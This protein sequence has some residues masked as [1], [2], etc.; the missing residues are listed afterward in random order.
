MTS[1]RSTI[2]TTAMLAATLVAVTGGAA[3]AAAH[4]AS[5]HSH[6]HSAVTVLKATLTGKYLHTTATDMKSN[7]ACTR[8]ACLLLAHGADPHAKQ[9][10][11]STALDVARLT[12]NAEL[13][14]L[15]TN[16]PE[17]G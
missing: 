2:K 11:G 17:M 9:N 4:A 13:E 8:I 1:P 5:T 3:T 7:E 15:L 12:R 16:R 14:A 10:G 6:A